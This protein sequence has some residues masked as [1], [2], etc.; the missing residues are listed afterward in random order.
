MSE[1]GSGGVGVREGTAARLRGPVS[2]CEKFKFYAELD[3]SHW[4]VWGGEAT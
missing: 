1:R 3:G 4:R 2:Q